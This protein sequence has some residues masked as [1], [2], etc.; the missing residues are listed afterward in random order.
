MRHYTR[1]DAIQP[2]KADMEH[3]ITDLDLRS[4]TPGSN[5]MQ[6]YDEL[7]NRGFYAASSLVPGLTDC[8]APV[9]IVLVIGWLCG[10]VSAA[11]VWISLK[12]LFLDLTMLPTIAWLLLAHHVSHPLPA[13]P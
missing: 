12:L 3:I 7:A 1:M 10:L 11:R 9:A 2:G 8:V 13:S 5:T 6:E 4:P